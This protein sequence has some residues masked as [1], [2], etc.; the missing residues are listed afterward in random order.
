MSL[1][2]IISISRGSSYIT[3]LHVAVFGTGPEGVT[4]M[5]F[6]A[7]TFDAVGLA[8]RCLCTTTELKKVFG[9]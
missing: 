8:T 5:T 6:S 7:S 9:I 2:L 4:S 1:D 3:I